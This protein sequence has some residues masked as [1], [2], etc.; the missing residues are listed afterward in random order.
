MGQ[1]LDT[2]QIKLIFHNSVSINRPDY[3]L[4][5]IQSEYDIKRSDL[6]FGFI[7]FILP[8]FLFP[9]LSLCLGEEKQIKTDRILTG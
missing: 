8:N 4:E 9:L 2:Y 3:M 6:F 7:F 5:L 1:V